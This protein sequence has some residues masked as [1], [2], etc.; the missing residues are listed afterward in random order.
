MSSPEMNWFGDIRVR[1]QLEKGGDA[2]SR[3]S[4]RIRVRFGVGVRLQKDLRAEI[5]L[6]SARSN[7]STNQSLGEASE[8]GSR[9]R[10]IGLDL[11]YAEWSPVHFAKLH[12][13]RF[14]QLHFRPGESQLVLD[15]DLT[16]EG[17]GATL[18]Y[19][20]YPELSVFGSIGSA[21][22]RENY[23]NYYAEDL[24]DNMLNFGQLGIQWSRESR[25]L[26]IGGGFYNFTSVQGSNFSDLAAGGKP[27]GNTEAAAGVIKNPY[28]P[29]QYFM[30]WRQQLGSLETGVFYEHIENSETSD[31]HRAFW[32]GVSLG[33]KKWDV[34]LGLTEIESDAVLALFTNSDLGNGT[35]DLKG[36]VGAARWKFLPGM[37]LRF[38]QM[39]ARTDMSG[40]NKEYRRSHLDVS[41]SF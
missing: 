38:T 10:F 27:N 1:Q 19:E 8:P 13:G 14:S 11:A 6:A 16:L 21:F 34:Q 37:S 12:V 39:V 5:R 41:A 35:S 9:R 31:P 17:A 2:E 4:T 22:L 33:Q 18:N 40:L 26:R 25:K 7:R 24:A 36:W 28:L 30:D 23:D 3:L 15:D 32:T 29:K 20:F